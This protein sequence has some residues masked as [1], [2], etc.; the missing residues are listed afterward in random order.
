MTKE[1]PHFEHDCDS[2]KFL[3]TLTLPEDNETSKRYETTVFDLYFCKQEIF[4]QTVISRYGN[5]GYEYSSGLTFAREGEFGN[6]NLLEAKRRAIKLGYLPQFDHDCS[7]CI[8]LGSVSY[9]KDSEEYKKSRYKITDFDLYFCPSELNLL[10]ARYGSDGDYFDRDSYEL[11][12]Q[13]NIDKFPGLVE[14]R[15]RAIELGHLSR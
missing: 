14:A 11:D 12:D 5:K 10:I 13:V 6:P 3:G 9:S 1:K 15:K 7:A 2:C 8:F 4:G